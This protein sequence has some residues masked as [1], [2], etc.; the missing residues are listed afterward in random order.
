MRLFFPLASIR[1]PLAVASR[2]SAQHVRLVTAICQLCLTSRDNRGQKSISSCGNSIGIL[3]YGLAV[4]EYRRSMRGIRALFHD[5]MTSL[6]QTFRRNCPDDAQVH[7]TF[8][9]MANDERD[10]R[11][12][13]QSNCEWR[14][15]RRPMNG[16]RRHI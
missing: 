13:V 15:E 1:S 9:S 8:M 4:T 7:A 5:G 6:A 16:P 3:A 2:G 12:Y 10:R 14:G 11:P